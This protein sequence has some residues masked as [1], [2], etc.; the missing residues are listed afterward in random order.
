MPSRYLPLLNQNPRVG[1]RHLSPELIAQSCN[2]TAISIKDGCDRHTHWGQ[3]SPPG[4]VL[5]KANFVMVKALNNLARNVFLQSL[6]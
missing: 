4:T 5:A 6:I 1:S 3:L 2:N